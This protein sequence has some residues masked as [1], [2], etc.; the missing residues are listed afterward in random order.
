MFSK[1]F[2]EFLQ[3][4][5]TWPWWVSQVFALVG[6]VFCITAMQQQKTTSMLWHRSIY[7]LLIFFGV[8]FLGQLSAIVLTGVAFVRNI[9]LLVLSKHE[10][11]SKETRVS[12]F[13][14]LALS[15]ILLNLWFWEN[16]LS[17]LSI[18]LGLAYLTAFAQSKPASVRKISLL[19]ASIAI[20]F[21]TLIFSPVNVLINI[22]VL[23]SAIVGL[24]RFDRKNV[25]AECRTQVN[26]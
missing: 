12:I 17:F 6:M 11:V 8:C 1:V 23:V 19:A 22:A 5:S 13:I 25:N 9:V 10:K 21:Y 3:S 16:Y 7:S 26:A 18:A 20:V 24:R 15:L 4:L 14:I 2:S